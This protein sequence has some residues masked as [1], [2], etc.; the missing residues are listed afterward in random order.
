MK[1]SWLSALS[2]NLRNRLR[3]SA[4]GGQW[5]DLEVP[6][7]AKI[8][9][10]GA[11]KL[12]EEAFWAESLLGRS[13]EKWRDLESLSWT[14]S[15]ENRRGLPRVYNESIERQRHVDVMVFM[16]DDVW[17]AD[18][19]WIEKVVEAL[20]TFDV[21]GVAG[22]RRR[23]Q[24][25]CTWAFNPAIASGFQWDHP[26]LS[27]RIAHGSE[28]LHEFDEF[29]A[30]PARCELLDGV[31]LAVNARVLRAAE[32]QFDTRFSFHFYD[33]DFCRSA[34]KAGFIMGTWP[35][36][37]IHA[38]GGSFSSPSWNSMKQLFL[39]KWSD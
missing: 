21:V 2:N 10:V 23:Q 17:L 38:S 34:R 20:R 16:H 25:Q 11:T 15:F 9:L 6:R 36:D 39:D 18:E 3:G 1:T 13:L 14:I 30:A 19:Q 26:Y 27:G 7:N 12:R 5:R 33:L 4:L 22:N 29:G 35:I 24:G 31:F 8:H 37:L 32:L 28:V